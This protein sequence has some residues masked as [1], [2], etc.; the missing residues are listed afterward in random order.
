[1]RIRVREVLVGAAA[2]VLAGLVAGV[3][4]ASPQAAEKAAAPA[5]KPLVLHFK[6]IP[7]ESFMDTLGQLGNN[8]HV[9]DVLKEVPIALNEPANSVVVIG[10]P[11]LGEFL[12][13]I[14]KGLD[15][16][17]EFREAMMQQERQQMEARLKFEEARHKMG[18]PPMQAGPGGPPMNRP[19]MRGPEMRQHMQPGTP[20]GPPAGMPG[21]QIRSMLPEGEPMGRMVIPHLASLL[22]PPARQALGINEEQAGRIQKV[23]AAAV[24][25]MAE[26]AKQMEE[27]VKNVPPEKRQEAA[28]QWWQKN[29]PERAKRAERVRRE[30]FEI[31]APEQRERAERWLR[32][33]PV[34]E[35][36][37]R[38]PH[39]LMGSDGPASPVP[40]VPASAEQ[41]ARFFLVQ[42]AGGPPQGMGWGGMEN[43]FSPEERDR[44]QQIIQRG[45]QLQFLDDPD[46][47]G[48]LKVTP[49]QEKKFQ[50]LKDRAQALFQAIGA[51][52]Q[53]RIKERM[54]TPDMTDEQRMAAIQDIR[55]VIADTVRGALNEVEGMV[56]EANGMLTEEQRSQLKVLA[57][58][59]AQTD[60]LTNGLAYLASTKA[61]E[62]FA[63]TYE[64]SEKI[65]MIVRDLETEVRKA[66]DDVAGP[67]KEP[68]A[69]ELRSEKFAPFLA[70]QKE[71]V[72]K[73]FDRILTILTGDQRDKVQKW[74]DTRM[75]RGQRGMGRGFGGR[76][77]GAAP[78][79]TPPESPK[80]AAPP[81]GSQGPS[82][83][84]PAAY[85]VSDAPASF[86][87]AQYAGG[88]PS[89][90]RSGA[91]G[92]GKRGNAG[93]PPEGGGKPSGNS[94]PQMAEMFQS[95]RSLSQLSDP[96]VA[97]ELK[98]SPQQQ[99]HIRELNKQA[100]ELMNLIRQE[101]Q[102]VTGGG[103]VPPG[104]SDQERRDF[105]KQKMQAA[106]EKIQPMLKEFESI[107]SE[108]M[109]V[110]TDEQKARLKTLGAQ[111]AQP[112]TTGLA[113]LTTTKARDEFAFSADQSDRIKSIVR[114]AEAEVK[115][116]LDEAFGPG[117]QPTAAELKSDKFAPLR[118]DQKAIVK[119]ALD[120]IM[121]ILTGDQRDKV[122]K[123]YDTR[124]QG[125]R[126][127][128]PAKGK[129]GGGQG[130]P[131]AAGSGG[132][133]YGGSNAGRGNSRGG[134][135]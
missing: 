43:L 49:E 88:P 30:V 39:G 93:G 99:G 128:G 41:P 32:E 103:G 24:G 58:Q 122:Q 16:P 94:G 15:Q 9:R 112:D 69:E 120:R 61:R 2:L 4:S 3:F 62:E 45:Q 42:N 89:E 68:T 85:A 91:S 56:G 51:D 26:T 46:V 6:Y 107:I 10:P 66:R 37:P 104:M 101:T 78:G 55:M 52:V 12:G 7:A 35:E 117:K 115:R 77:G 111:H 59:R 109:A 27:A 113:Y 64:Q 127:Q 81:A 114:D 135:R 73:A 90:R 19:E 80:P 75:A 130:G 50:D 124:A 102:G 31:L 118:E 36:M 18:L 47:R 95:A 98:M 13:A 100:T 96:D 108:A 129:P 116:M 28:A 44:I 132:G 106:A 57:P 48:E 110:L 60:Q 86:F 84:P 133:G 134:T 34:T 23:L 1:M 74:Y 76:M 79:G 67:G 70:Q 105:L 53:A 21:P 14:A 83:Q 71:M 123:W 92:Q 87:L 17:N 97:R 54:P 65:K 20:M 5:P 119:K 25:E 22:S 8:P 63:F 131:P 40:S 38:R 11:E 82:V 29:T 126:A 125:G 121:T 33:H 72:K